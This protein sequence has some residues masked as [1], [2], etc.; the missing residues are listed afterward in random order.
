[1]KKTSILCLDV[2][3]EKTLDQLRRIGVVHLKHAQPPAGESVEAA[4][5]RRFRIGR[6]LDMLPKTHHEKPGGTPV[7]DT[8]ALIWEQ[9]EKQKEWNARLDALLIEEKRLEPYGSFEPSLIRRLAEQGIYV[10]LY[11]LGARE[12]PELPEGAVLQV[13]R[14]TKDGTYAAV[15][16]REESKLSGQELRL[17]EQSLN[18]VRE[19]IARLRKQLED[20]MAAIHAQGGER[21]AVEQALLQA[22]DALHYEEARAGMGGAERI[23]YLSGYCPDES[24]PRIRAAAAAHGWGLVVN[25][26]DAGELAPTKIR[27]PRWVKP[28]QSVFD[29]TGILPGYDEVD[30][31][32]CFLIALSIFFAMLVGDAGYGAVFLLLT[33]L[34][35]RKMKKAPAY[36]FSFMYIMSG[37]TIIWG[38][39]TGTYFGIERAPWLPYVHWFDSEHNIML[40]CF[41]LGA[42]HLSIAHLWNAW[43][44]RNTPQAAAHIGW[45]LSTWTMFFMAGKFVLERPFPAWM[46]GVFAA[47]LVLIVLFMTPVKQIKAE[48]FN[49]VMLPLTVINN[50]TDVVSYLRLF[51]VG[52]A[53]FAV[54]SSFNTMLLENGWG[55]IWAAALKALVL[56]LGHALNVALACLGILVHG[57]RLN[58]LEF[59][60]HMGLQWKGY[61][62]EPFRSKAV[63]GELRKANDSR[64][65]RTKTVASERRWIM[66]MFSMEGR[67]NRAKYFWSMLAIAIAYQIILVGIDVVVGSSGGDPIAAVAIGFIVGIGIAIICA[68]QVV[69]RLHDLDRPGSHYWLSLIPIYNI[70]FNLLILFK[71]GTEG[72]NKYG[73]DPLAGE[74]AL[75]NQSVPLV[76]SGGRAG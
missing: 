57:V 64:P 2:D 18:A 54:A 26:P 5:T 16:A 36:P 45:V 55:P 60:S 27:Y 25:D 23:A 39:L 76:S 9:L 33:L 10:K 47:G 22:E 56:F 68:F 42:I 15:V 12:V 32:P 21:P 51:A 53:S 71:K 29:V 11:K 63:D 65:Q 8:I 40:L 74:S 1:M 17:P 13:L 20:S 38:V 28:I 49:H 3:R 41:T 35:R 69:K 70:Y 7:E 75:S 31:S 30:V 43:L 61:R 34:A 58:T 62:Y 48:W 50:F 37:A 52:T 24:M 6:A 44:M 59:S 14:E 66:G 4:R 46:G 67:Y 72:A 19:E 73:A